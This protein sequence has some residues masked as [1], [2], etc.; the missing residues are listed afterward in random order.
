M[1]RVAKISAWVLAASILLVAALIGT[2]WIAGNPDPGRGWIERLT[3]RLTS[4][5]VK[6]SGLGGSF[7][8]QLTLDH[9]ELID[10]S[11]VWLTADD[12]SLRWSP[13]RWLERRIYVDELQLKRLHMERAP[14]GDG[15]SGGSTSIPHIDVGKFSM[16]AVELGAALVGTPTTLS[17]RGKLELRSVENADADVEARRL[18]GEGEYTLHLK[19]DPKR[20]D[21]TLAVHEPAGGP[22]ENLLSLPGLGA[23][24]ATATVQGPRNAERVDVVLDAGQLHADVHGSVDLT[25][26]SAEVEYSLK[27]AAMAPRPDVAWAEVALTGNWHGTL[28]A[29]TADGRLEVHGLKILGATQIPRL[30]AEL[31]ARAGKLVVH[32]VVEG[33]EIPGPQPRLLAKDPLTIDA[34]LELD[35][36]ARPLD[37]TATHS[38]FK[39]RAHADTTPASGAEQCATV[40]LTVFALSPVAAFAGHELRG[41]ATINGRLAPGGRGITV[42]ADADLGVTGGAAAWIPTVGPKVTLKIEGGM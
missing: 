30:N 38:L 25:H 8:T 42:A 10:R 22:L 34:S 23:L 1:R 24:S 27:S 26:Q 11:G 5:Y 15:R 35:A 13:L 28:T 31:A 41:N 19:L 16:D 20:M 14:V 18:D 29:P 21:G 37:L 17:L 32:G 33:L 40:A 4:G 3:Y 9:L 36:A 39:L 7:P 2:V 12:I 6:V